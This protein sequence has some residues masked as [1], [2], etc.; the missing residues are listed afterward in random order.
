[1]PGIEDSAGSSIRTRYSSKTLL[2]SVLA[3]IF[4]ILGLFL[5]NLIIFVSIPL[6]ILLAFM[7]L[8]SE[9]PEGQIEVRRSLE[10]LQ[11]NEHDLCKVRLRVKNSGKSDIPILQVRDLVPRLLDGE[12]TQNGFTLAL[13][14]GESKD[15]FY[16]L[17]CSTF[18]VFSIGP[19]ILSLTDLSGV[20]ESETVI[21]LRSTLVVLPEVQ[22]R[23]SKFTIR[24]K[25]TKPWPGE[26][27]S[28]RTGQGMN[29]HSVRPLVS[30]ES[31]KRINWKA[32][33]RSSDP[34]QLFVNEFLAE[35]GADA[36]IIV[37]GREISEIGTR[38]NSTFSYSIRA[39]LSV[40]ERLLHDRNRVGLLTI[41]V[42]GS[43]VPAGYG[44]RQF[45]KMTLALLDLIP[46]ES[47]SLE[48][49]AHNLRAFYPNISQVVLVSPLIDD[50]A[51]S[52]A[53]DICRAG[54]DLIV[55]SPNPLHFDVVKTKKGKAR[56]WDIAR[57]LAQLERAANIEQLRSVN[58]L[59]ID[60]NRSEPLQEI[61]EAHGRVWA[62]HFIR[63][64]R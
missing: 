32:S 26:I 27:P 64:G 15:L 17:Y 45:V 52:A 41:G 5:V 34:D 6:V 46:G 8:R 43:N 33:A 36:L 54:Y 22:E 24:P 14:S 20:F 2:L 61:I 38:P 13:R 10:K 48:G 9:K 58:A 7:I 59:V 37:D 25:K 23:L 57:K 35:L 44:R 21:N 4:F 53:A 30:G 18:G 39:A 49:M 62:T 60:W 31:L 47:R 16:E 51:F 29:F 56:E 50:S 19:V 12:S 1:M 28:R 55:I 63:A 40:A 11:V 3:L 42:R